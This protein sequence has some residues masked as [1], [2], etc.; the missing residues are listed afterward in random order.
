[1]TTKA[2]AYDHLTARYKPEWHA[3]RAPVLAPTYDTGWSTTRCSFCGS[4]PPSELA[5]AIK[6]GARVSWA[7]FKYGWPHKVYVDG[8][9]NPFAGMLAVRSMTYCGKPPQEE[10]DAG[11]WE[12]Y[13]VGF[14]RTTGEPEFSYR[15]V[16][17]ARPEPATTHGKFYT[18]HLQD[19]TPEE[20]VIIERA[21]GISFTFDGGK[22]SWKK[23]EEPGA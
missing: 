22:V 5:A 6:A 23:F 16:G 3:P 15:I 8:V 9:P 18:E 1:M 10:L 20:R 21:M 12:R 14:D 2:H 13:Q 19:A 17:E 11:K 7:D 4:M